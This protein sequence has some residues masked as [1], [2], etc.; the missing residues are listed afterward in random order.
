MM[1]GVWCVVYGISQTS[2]MAAGKKK[3]LSMDEKLE[4]TLEYFHETSEPHTLKV[5]SAVFFLENCP[6]MC[7]YVCYVLRLG[8]ISSFQMECS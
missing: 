2:S 7:V 6:M 5:C 3:G 4:K 8:S 1:F